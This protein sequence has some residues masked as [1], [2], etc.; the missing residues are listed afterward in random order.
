[1]DNNI[2]I[3]KNVIND[4]DFYKNR[5]N[6]T[7]NNRR[8][9]DL[10][11]FYQ[12]KYSNDYSNANNI[13]NN[14]NNYQILENNVNNVNNYQMLENNANNYQIENENLDNKNYFNNNENK[15]L[16]EIFANDIEA[17]NNI[18]KYKEKII[19]RSH[20]VEEN[21]KK[22]NEYQ[23]NKFKRV[24][25]RYTNE[26]NNANK[27]I[28][29]NNGENFD[30]VNIPLNH[31]NIFFMKGKTPNKSMNYINSN[32]PNNN[33][34]NNRV[35]NRMYK[36]QSTGN[37]FQNNF[38]LS[39]FEQGKNSN[40]SINH[41]HEYLGKRRTDITNNELINIRENKGFY[42]YCNKKMEILLDNQKMME[43]KINKEK[44]N[45][46]NSR[47]KEQNEINMKNKF[48]NNLSTQNL[49]EIKNSKIKY[50]NLLDEQI[51]NNINNK[52][53]NENLTLGDVVLN[54]F[55]LNKKSNVP[56]TNFINK[57]RFVDVNPYNHRNYF[58]GN[59][60]LTN[61]VIINPQ[62]QYNSNRYILPEIPSNK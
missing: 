21:Y 37:I 34:V 7:I 16:N 33:F 51:Q 42:E 23:N 17:E 49:L 62:D 6:D 50:K 54:K 59:S 52:L 53:L 32:K 10:E 26:N 15:K 12:K 24:N 5:N 14:N 39:N 1:M 57:N 30:N 3:L 31:K 60:S 27:N 55:Y 29:I 11:T 13:F 47:I 58:L 41:N 36:S 35:G 40:N 25:M 4:N 22:F 38:Y 28:N 20:I 61:N 2:Q 19:N 9:F 56:N 8:I 43:E 45:K 44:I 46:Y 18:G 48:Y